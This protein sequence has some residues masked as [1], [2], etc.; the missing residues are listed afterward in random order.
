MARYRFELFKS[1]AN[2]NYY[3]NFRAPNNE[4]MCQSEGYTTK[5]SAQSAINVI[6]REAAAAPIDDKTPATNSLGW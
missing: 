4:I 2:S 3:F 5:A 6:K 1:N